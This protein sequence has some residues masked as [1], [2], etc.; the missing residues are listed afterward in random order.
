MENKV[1][2]YLEEMV[3]FMEHLRL[4]SLGINSK[5]IFEDENLIKKHINLNDEIFNSFEVDSDFNSNDEERYLNNKM[6]NSNFEGFIHDKYLNFIQ[7]FI[8]GIENSNFEIWNG[9]K[10]EEVAKFLQTG[11]DCIKKFANILKAIKKA[12]SIEEIKNSIKNIDYDLIKN[13]IKQIYNFHMKKM[14][15]TFSNKEKKELIKNFKENVKR[16][17]YELINCDRKILVFNFKKISSNLKFKFSANL[18]NANMLC[19]LMQI[20][21]ADVFMD[22]YNIY[23]NIPS[24]LILKICDFEDYFNAVGIQKWEIENIKKLG[25]FNS[26]FFE[27]IRKL[28]YKAETKQLALKDIKKFVK[29]ADSLKFGIEEYLIAFN[30]VNLMNVN[31]AFNLLNSAK[32]KLRKIFYDAETK[33]KEI[34]EIFIANFKQQ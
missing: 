2:F 18:F 34:N 21:E 9:V 17:L 33:I 22:K 25:I 3:K 8:K 7:S 10:K 6:K 16:F 31:E 23:D 26:K 11:I 14:K 4:R 13:K 24:G 32:N 27:I 28:A 5:G 15:G 1:K 30:R 20:F 29:V 19:N 12:S